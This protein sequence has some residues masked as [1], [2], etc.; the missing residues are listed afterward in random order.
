MSQNDR[1]KNI[2]NRV[3]AHI[4]EEQRLRKLMKVDGAL[5]IEWLCGK[6]GSRGGIMSLRECARRAR[7][8]PTYLSHC[9][10]GNNTLSYVAYLRLHDLWIQSRAD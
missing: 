5:L 1:G 3:R 8:S 4:E 7:L 9:R 2:P 6:A 10:S